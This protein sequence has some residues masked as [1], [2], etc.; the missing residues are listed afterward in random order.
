MN[1]LYYNRD[2]KSRNVEHFPT[3]ILFLRPY[4]IDENDHIL[5]GEKIICLNILCYER[6]L[7]SHGTDEEKLKHKQM[8]FD[9][10][11]NKDYHIESKEIDANNSLY[12]A[13]Y[14]IYLAKET[15]N[16]TEMIDWIKKIFTINNIPF[17]DFKE[18]TFNEFAD[19][20][21]IMQMFSLENVKKMEG[22]LG[23]DWWLG[24]DD[25]K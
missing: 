6:L 16:I 13:S 12:Q 17:E 24:K 23:K 9:K 1:W 10:L 21:A 25:G 18:G 11:N 22:K 19:T 3:A 14:T 5:V 2:E 15:I 8:Y 20:N 4:K 7:K